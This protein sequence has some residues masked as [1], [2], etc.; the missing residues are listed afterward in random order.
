MRDILKDLNASYYE[1]MKYSGHS[2]TALYLGSTDWFDFV[3]ST[4]GTTTFDGFGFRDGRARYRG[5]P[6][7]LV[8]A[9]SHLQFSSS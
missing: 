8:N 1:A 9:E 7:Y 4:K 6:I 2:P 5:V 3:Q